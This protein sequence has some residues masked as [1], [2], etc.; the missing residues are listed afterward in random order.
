MHRAP[1]ATFIG[2]ALLVACAMGLSVAS[3]RAAILP[4]DRGTAFH[5]VVITTCVAEAILGAGLFYLLAVPHTVRRTSPAVRIRVVVLIVIWFFV[6]LVTGA[7]AVAPANAGTRYTENILLVQAIPTFLLLLAVYFFDRQDVLL[8]VREEI[9]Q[10][11]RVDLQTCAGDVDAMIESIRRIAERRPQNAAEL[12]RLGRLLDTL[13]T[14]LLCASP[15]AQRD[16]PR[17][18]QPISVGE[19]KRQLGQLQQ[20]VNR[21]ADSGDE[22][23][24]V[25][26]AELR[27]SVD[28]ANASLRR[29]EDAVTL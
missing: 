26:L 7:I 12:D 15:V 25:R 13:K 2:I 19:I 20:G 16:S 17:P 21:L 24:E 14:Q 8:Q 10:R 4:E 29:R 28:A 18:V 5:T 11:E 6:L 23:F 3:F 27:R 22:Q 9:P 1:L